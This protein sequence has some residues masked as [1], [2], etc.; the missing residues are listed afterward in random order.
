MH[1]HPRVCSL[2]NFAAFSPLALSLSLFSFI[3]LAHTIVQSIRIQTVFY[4]FSSGT[5]VTLFSYRNVIKHACSCEYKIEYSQFTNLHVLFIYSLRDILCGSTCVQAL[6]STRRVLIYI[7]I[8]GSPT[9]YTRTLHV[10]FINFRD[11]VDVT[12]NWKMKKKKRKKKNVVEQRHR[13]IDDDN[14]LYMSTKK[15]KH[16]ERNTH[17]SLLGHKWVR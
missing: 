1:A 17:G 11:E 10:L 3:F 16:E 6:W 4:S 2:V 13:T 15:R 7:F 5:F 8:A 9:I 14:M 12:M